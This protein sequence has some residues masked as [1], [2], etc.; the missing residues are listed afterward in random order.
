MDIGTGTKSQLPNLLLLS[1]LLLIY[2]IQVYMSRSTRQ[3]AKKHHYQAGVWGFLYLFCSRSIQNELARTTNNTDII[4]T[5]IL[6]DNI[7]LYFKCIIRIMVDNDDNKYDN[8]SDNNN[9]NSSS[10][11]SDSNKNKCNQLWNAEQKKEQCGGC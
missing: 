6:L 9:N 3:H 2:V 8:E 10:N 11:C 7:S 5:S 4:D 1:S